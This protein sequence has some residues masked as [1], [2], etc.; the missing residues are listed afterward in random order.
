MGEIVMANPKNYWTVHQPDGSW[1]VKREGVDHPI[2]NF[3]RQDA[4]WDLTQ[5]LARQ[6]QGEAFLQNRRGQI[7]ERNTYGHDPRTTKG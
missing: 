3:N 7:R 4:A 2:A 1:G 6:S 5:S